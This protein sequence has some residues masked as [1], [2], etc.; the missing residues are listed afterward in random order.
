MTVTAAVELVLRDGDVD[1]VGS[2]AGDARLDAD[3]GREVVVEAE[4]A[5]GDAVLVGADARLHGVRIVLLVRHQVDEAGERARA[6]EERA[7][8]AHDLDAGDVAEI[9]AAVGADVR[10]REQVVVERRAVAQDEH[11]VAVVVRRADA[12]DGDRVVGAVVVEGEAARA[13][14][15]LGDG[16]VAEGAQ[17]L[18]VDDADGARRVVERL[19][20]ARDRGH[21]AERDHLEVGQLGLLAGLHLD[22]PLDRRVAAEQDPHLA[23]ADGDVLDH[24]GGEAHGAA[25]DLDDRVALV[26]AHDHDAGERRELGR[27]PRHVPRDHVHLPRRGLVA[28]PREVEQVAPRRHLEAAR[29]L[30]GRGRLLVVDVHRR[31]RRALHAHL[32]RADD[33]GERERDDGLGAELGLDH[34]RGR[35]LVA[36]DLGDDPVLAGRER[37]RAGG[38][39]ADA[40]VPPVDVDRRAGRIRLHPEHGDAGRDAQDRLLDVGDLLRVRLLG[41]RVAVV[42]VRVGEAAELLVGAGDVEDDVLVGD[43]PVRREEVLER[44][45][46]LA[47][48]VVLGG[49]LELEIRALV[50]GAAGERGAGPPRRRRGRGRGRARRGGG[51]VARSLVMEGSR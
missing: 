28:V 41:E 27:G 13:A 8:A 23:A 34:G 16:G 40:Q 37:E 44:L 3:L 6:V 29:R 46:E 10:A 25:V 48:A 12:A 43:E 39:A 33:A 18:P 22:L 47:L 14:E 2:R 11:A 45:A 49:D 9:V 1:A 19:G 24:G 17:L 26:G 35:E 51:G 30:A 32:H 21:L 38:R 31:A 50:G 42:A 20:V 7:R 15:R 5:A 36:L 4:A